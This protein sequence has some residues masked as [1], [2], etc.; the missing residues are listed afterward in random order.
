[1]D[2]EAM[3]FTA[4]DKI[5]GGEQLQMLKAMLPYLGGKN[6]R[7]FA[8]FIKVI[9]IQNILSFFNSSGEMSI[10]TQSEGKF[11][12]TD[13]LDDIKNYAGKSQRENIEQAM[14]MIQIMSMMNAF[15]DGGSSPEDMMSA[16]LSPEQQAMFSAY[17]SMFTPDASEG[18]EGGGSETEQ[19]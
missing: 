5:A 10:H 6:Q 13:M 11:S 12:M 9:E 7:F 1:M 4:L 15:T 19:P 14:S 8:V 3:P 16:F 2:E 18:G 17:E